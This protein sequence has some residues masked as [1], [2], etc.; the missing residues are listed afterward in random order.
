[1]NLVTNGRLKSI[2]WSSIIMYVLGFWLSAS[3]MLDFIVL[4]SLFAAGIM[5]SSDFASAGHLIF[6]IFNRIELF[7]AASILTCLL[8][9]RSSN[10]IPHSQVKTES[11]SLILSGLLLAI[12]LIYTYF[13][14]PQM[15]AMGMQLNLFEASYALPDAMVSM[16]GIYW[17]LEVTKLVIGTIVLRWSYNSFG[18]VK[19]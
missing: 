9:I 6:S 11:I 17:I 4:P 14:T 3:I 18:A 2:N 8:V 7:S 19:S 5:S 15:S 16:H 12:A 10:F 1:M 13:L